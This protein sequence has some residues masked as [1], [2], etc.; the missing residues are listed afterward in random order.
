MK[1]ISALIVA[2]LPCAVLFSGCVSSKVMAPPAAAAPD[3]PTLAVSAAAVSAP[4]VLKDG[5]ISQP[6]QTDVAAGGRAIFNFS[7]AK[8]GDYVIQAVVNAPDEDSNSFYLNIDAQPEDPLMIWDI[9][10]TKG[11][12][13]RIVSWRGSGDDSSD[14]FVPKRFKLTAGA[15]QLI[16]VGREAAQLKSVAIRPAAN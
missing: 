9:A 1:I 14:E 2:S 12:E 16:I 11:F 3:A 6:H 10:V 7:V 5:A 13:E 15:H 4:L 8:D